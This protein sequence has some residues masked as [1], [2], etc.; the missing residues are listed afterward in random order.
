MKIYTLIS[1]ARKLLA[2]DWKVKVQAHHLQG[3]QLHS[4]RFN[5]LLFPFIRLCYDDLF[6]IFLT[7]APVNIQL[8][9]IPTLALVNIT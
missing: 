3:G 4:E 9:I 5:K 2:R 1:K 8:R 7:L 6:I